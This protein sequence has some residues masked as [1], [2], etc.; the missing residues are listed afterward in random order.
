MSVEVLL[1]LRILL[2][3]DL[4]AVAPH[5]LERL[6]AIFAPYYG[7]QTKDRPAM[8]DPIVDFTDNPAA[9]MAAPFGIGFAR[10]DS[11]SV[12]SSPSAADPSVADPQCDWWLTVLC[13][14]IV[15]KR[16]TPPAMLERLR[17]LLFGSTDLQ[18]VDILITLIRVSLKHNPH[19]EGCICTV[20]CM[21]EMVPQSLVGRTTGY[22]ILGNVFE[23]GFKEF[24]IDMWSAKM[25]VM[26][27]VYS[28]DCRDPTAV[29]LALRV[30]RDL[31]TM[32]RPPMRVAQQHRADAAR[33]ALEI[34]LVFLENDRLPPNVWELVQALFDIVGDANME[35]CATH[36][37]AKLLMR[38]QLQGELEDPACTACE[39]VDCALTALSSALERRGVDSEWL[40]SFARLY[41]HVSRINLQLEVPR[42]LDVAKLGASDQLARVVELFELVDNELAAHMAPLYIGY[43]GSSRKI[44]KA[45]YLEEDS[46][47]ADSLDAVL[48]P[49]SAQVANIL[50]AAVRAAL[51]ALWARMATCAQP[52]IDPAGIEKA[53]ELLDGRFGSYEISERALLGFILQLLCANEPDDASRSR[54]DPLAAL[55]TLLRVHNTLTLLRLPIEA[56]APIHMGDARSAVQYF[57]PY[58]APFIHIGPNGQLCPSLHTGVHYQCWCRSEA[59]NQTDYDSTEWEPNRYCRKCDFRLSP[60]ELCDVDFK[61][62]VDPSHKWPGHLRRSKQSEPSEPS[63]RA[64]RK[65]VLSV[66]GVFLNEDEIPVFK[67]SLGVDPLAQ[68]HNAFHAAMAPWHESHLPYELPPAFTPMMAR[69]V[70]NAIRAALVTLRRG[71]AIEQQLAIDIAIGFLDGKLADLT[72]DSAVRDDFMWRLLITLRGQHTADPQT[73]AAALHDIYSVL[74]HPKVQYLIANGIDVHLGNDADGAALVRLGHPHI[75]IP[76]APGKHLCL[77]QP[78]KRW[79]L[80]KLT[81]ELT[82]WPSGALFEGKLDDLDQLLVEQLISMTTLTYPPIGHV[83]NAHPG[84]FT[85]I[86]GSTRSRLLPAIASNRFTQLMQRGCGFGKLILDNLG[87]RSEHQALARVDW[88]SLLAVRHQYNRRVVEFTPWLLTLT[89]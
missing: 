1:L 33:D 85:F 76:A 63:G 24:S 32:P 4:D 82:Q 36:L 10:V 48:L 27:V 45:V 74:S 54:V 50:I 20:C 22:D 37:A 31:R 38:L 81:S 34:L 30:L 53:L 7:R 68:A 23:K 69:T 84:K 65:R 41:R 67:T 59:A 15:D 47:D 6:R 56:G 87:D 51:G 5:T 44:P 49:E 78:G 71:V 17:K 35:N 39:L 26:R 73:F 55:E 13:S 77:S 2:A 21:G 89:P 46:L 11:P 66:V 70:R 64:V 72:L 83:R 14:A 42:A 80:V 28:E 61:M 52:I 29:L 62:Y 58:A 8:R 25:W 16:A 12:D 43:P 88:S 79:R 9:I 3:T 19:E 57:H 86:P 60:R 75:H 18:G 40:L